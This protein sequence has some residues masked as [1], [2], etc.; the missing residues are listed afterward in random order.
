[1]RA[2]AGASRDRRRKGG[3][4]T[5]GLALVLFGLVIVGVMLAPNLVLKINARKR[6]HES[7]RLAL[8]REGLVTAMQRAQVVPAAA[9]W[10]MA[11]AGALG[12]DQTEVEQTWPDFASDTNIRRILL[13]DPGLGANT[14]PFTQTVAGVSGPATN[15]LGA[16]SRLMLVS[17]T[18]RS[19]TMP[20][21]NGI[22]TLAAFDAIWNWVYHPS[23]KAPPSGWPASWNGNGDWLHVERI[24]LASL[25]HRVTLE[26]LQYSLNGSSLS[27][28]TTQIN[29]YFL[30]NGLLKVHHADG[31]LLQARVILHDD[32][33]RLP[34]AS[35]SNIYYMT[36]NGIPTDTDGIPTAQLTNP[37]PTA[38][39]LPN[40]D[41]GRDAFAGLLLAKGGSGP[42]ESD[43]TKIQKWITAAGSITINGNVSLTVFSAMKDFSTSKKG[44]LKVYLVECDSAGTALS[45]LGTVTFTRNPWDSASTGTWVEHTIDFG[46]VTHAIPPSRRLGLVIT[47]NNGSD[48]DMWFA[49]WTVNYNSRLTLPP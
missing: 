32:T 30:R 2:I 44:Q 31:V 8:I 47:V 10:S 38:T 34:S 28:V 26:N 13:I 18:K 41:P 12:M 49:Y 46:S 17:N 14:L 48:D 27:N 20:V 24:N 25:F 7:E 45:T 21:T 29:G 35:T 4:S 23:T 43:A 42:G 19:L 16:S 15:L 9:G 37:A 1:M 33:F 5:L 36:G 40:Y 3:Y 39:T 11:T 22:P 6:D